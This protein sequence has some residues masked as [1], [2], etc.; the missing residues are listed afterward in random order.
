MFEA[1]R[2]LRDLGGLPAANGATIRAGSLFRSAH[3]ADATDADV[4]LLS[5]LGLARVIDFRSDE[6]RASE[7]E[8]RLPDGVERID[9]PIYDGAGQSASI[10]EILMSGDVERILDEY[11]DG[12]SAEIK[13][14]GAER[15][16][17][18]PG[19]RA[20]FARFFAAILEP[21]H[22]PVLWHCSAGKDRAGFAATIAMLALG[23]PRET[24]I[25]EYLASNDHQRPL[26]DPRGE[27]GAE[28][29][30]AITPFMRQHRSEIDVQLDAI[31]SGWRDVDAF[32]TDGLGADPD[33][34][35]GFRRDLIG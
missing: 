4:D 2:N 21:H 19:T 15:M 34:L 23:V 20:H 28:V 14:R 22:R 1:V 29:R 35:A 25:A 16:V 30:A 10:R 33:A 6:D 27:R 8:D 13:R 9:L 24:V 18:D 5:E 3:L 32:L 12:R 17:T 31:A 26:P 7:G 11:G